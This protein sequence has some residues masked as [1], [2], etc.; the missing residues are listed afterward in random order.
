M[1]KLKKPFLF[2]LC[3]L[4]I[5]LIAGVFSGIYQLDTF[6]EDVISQVLA[7]VGSKEVVILVTAVQTAVYAFV[8]GLFGYIMADKIGLIKPFKITKKPLLVTVLVS[9]FGGIIFSLDYWVFGSYFSE[10]QAADKAGMTLSGV[11]AS[12]LYG[13]IIEEV[14]MRLFFMTL[15]ALI[16][17][18]IFARKYSKDNIPTS[19]F[20]VANII[21][22]VVFAAL[23]LPATI[24]IFGE[25]T[26]LLVFRCFLLNGCFAIVF[27]EL[28]RRYGIL[29]AMTSHALFHIVSKLFWFV[30]I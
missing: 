20:V 21:A 30:F 13:G 29:Y 1:T 14:M 22:A 11:L 19:V 28:Y 5:A 16:I 7:Q 15:I 23:H 9:F 18:M 8:C 24:S 2:A 12:V 10:I 26:P 6:S 25:L 27:G 3:L 4:P 17:R